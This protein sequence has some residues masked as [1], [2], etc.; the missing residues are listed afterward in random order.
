M[1]FRLDSQFVLKRNR[2]P[3][4][5]ANE[6]YSLLFC[7]LEIDRDRNHSLAVVSLFTELT[8]LK[9]AQLKFQIPV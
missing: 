1:V 4:N 3:Q 2:C 8:F 9:R 6:G 7:L 5:S